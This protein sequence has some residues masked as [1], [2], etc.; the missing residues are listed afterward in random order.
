MLA[1]ELRAEV[2]AML[3]RLSPLLLQVMIWSTWAIMGAALIFT[4]MAY[5]AFPDHSSRASW[6]APSCPEFRPLLRIVVVT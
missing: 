3:A 1:A 4:L 5:N 2:S 6:C